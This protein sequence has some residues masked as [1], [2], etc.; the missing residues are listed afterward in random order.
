MEGPLIVLI[1]I[2]SVLIAI[3]SSSIIISS[4]DTHGHPGKQELCR[5]RPS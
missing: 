2:L 4:Q 3:L 5:R 1:T